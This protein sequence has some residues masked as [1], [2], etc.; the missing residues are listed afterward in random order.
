ML[1]KLHGDENRCGAQGKQ[2][3][4]PCSWN[5]FSRFCEIT[6]LWIWKYTKGEDPLIVDQEFTVAHD[7]LFALC[8]AE[9]DAELQTDDVDVG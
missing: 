2:F 4:L 7:L 6:F 8:V 9:P 5:G 1:S 3:P